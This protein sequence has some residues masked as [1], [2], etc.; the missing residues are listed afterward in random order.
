MWIGLCGCF[1]VQIQAYLTLSR[2]SDK[3]NVEKYVRRVCFAWCCTVCFFV[4][5]CRV[6]QQMRRVSCCAVLMSLLMFSM[7]SC[8]RV[9]ELAASR[10]ACPFDTCNLWQR[11][12]ELSADPDLLGY[13]WDGGSNHEYVLPD[14]NVGS[15]LSHPDGQLALTT[16]PHNRLTASASDSPS[17]RFAL[18][19]E[20]FWSFRC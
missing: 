20:V 13:V 10:F 16:L 5:A 6:S 14:A 19:Y 1:C 9:A 11:I 4:R 15:G 3:G 7:M 17:A 2:Y 8:C 12:K 18:L